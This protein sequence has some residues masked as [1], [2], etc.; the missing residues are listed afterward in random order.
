[1][2]GI[3]VKS[4]TKRFTEFPNCNLSRKLVQLSYVFSMMLK[5]MS[6]SSTVPLGEQK[7]CR[8]TAL[9]APWELLIGAK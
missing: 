3:F 5:S 6:F 8:F 9:V 4:N 7:K 1:M 2:N